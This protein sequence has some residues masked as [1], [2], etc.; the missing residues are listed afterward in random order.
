[1]ENDMK[2]Y[3]PIYYRKISSAIDLAGQI[4]LLTEL[5]VSGIKALLSYVLRLDSRTHYHGSCKGVGKPFPRTL[6][7][8]PM[9]LLNTGSVIGN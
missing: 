7:A 3:R 8:V 5:R 1:M 9:S 6:S 4:Y 2:Y